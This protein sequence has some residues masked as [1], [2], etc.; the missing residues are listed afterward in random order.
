MHNIGVNM[1][2]KF[3]YDRLRNDRALGN[4][5]SDNN[6]N[7]KTTRRTTTTIFKFVA[8]GDLFPSPRMI[9]GSARGLVVEQKHR[10]GLSI[11]GRRSY[12]HLWP[13]FTHL[14]IDW[15]RSVTSL[16]DWSIV[17]ASSCSIHSAYYRRDQGQYPAEIMGVHIPWGGAAGWAMAR[18]TFWLDGPQ[19][20]WPHP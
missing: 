4:R 16:R 1:C 11:I 17:S 13:L 14:F 5:K 18:P 3:H 6:K 15:W 20:V 7:P 10:L 8:I 2:E 12:D 19:C 9:S